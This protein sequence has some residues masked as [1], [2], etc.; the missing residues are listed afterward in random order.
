MKLVNT[1]VIKIVENDDENN[2]V[3]IGHKKKHKE[4]EEKRREGKRGK[5]G[6]CNI[7]L[8]LNM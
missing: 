2:K 8:I 5:E 6:F 7:E 3:N 4:K 1:G